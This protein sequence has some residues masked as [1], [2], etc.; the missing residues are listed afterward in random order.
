[1][2][3][4]VDVLLRARMEASEVT[5]SVGQIQKALQGLTLPKGITNDLEKEFNKLGPLLKDYQR[6]LNK[7][8]SNKKDLQNFSALKEQIGDTFGSIKNLVNQANSQTIKL[9]VDTQALDQLQHKITSKTEA[10]EKAYSQVFTKSINSANITDQFNKILQASTKAPTIKG[11]IG[12]AQNLFDTKDYAGYNAELDKIKSKILSLKTTKINLAESLGVKNAEKDL[13]AA[14]QKITSFFNKLKVNENKV[15]AIE[16]LKKELKDLGME[17]EGLDLASKIKGE[18]EISN[19]ASSLDQ[20]QQ[21]FRE[22]GDAAGTAASGILSMQ[23]Q[24]GQLRQSTQYFFSLRNMINL[25][26]RGIDDAVKSIKELDAAMT[27]TAVVTN[28]SVGD[29]WNKLPEYTA[30]ANALGATVQDMYEATTLYYQQGLNTEQAMSIAAETMKMARI[31]GLDAADATDKMTAALRGFNMEINEASA[32]RI[33]DVYSNLAA[34]TASNTEELGTAM[35]RTASIAH[36]AGMSFEGTAAFLAQ[37]IETTREPAENI[38]TAMKTVIARMQEMKKNPLEISEVDGEEVDYNKVDAALKSIGVSLQDVNGNFRDNDKILLEISQRWDS[39]SQTQ[40]R[41]VATT[42]AGSRQQS[43]F[44][45]MVSDYERTMQLM[46]YA[47]DS[48]GASQEQFEKTMDSMEAKLNK[49]HNAWQAFTMGIANNTFVKGAVDGLTFLIDGVNNLIDKLSNGSKTIKSFLSLFTAFTALKGLGRLANAAIGGLGGLLDPQSSFKQGLFGGGAIGN[50][51]S[52]NA[53]QA[54]MISDPIV[55]AINRLYQAQTGKTV[56]SES[57]TNAKADYR[58]FKEANT[59]LR[60][61]ISQLKPGEE[62]SI[63]EAYQHIGKLDNKQQ[64]A[65]L[66]QLPGLS[67]SLQKNGIQFNAKDISRSS[68]DLLNT[69]NKEINQGLQNK[70]L[71]SQAVLK[72]FG[73][74]EDFRKT[75]ATYGDDYIKA[76]EQ[77]LSQTANKYRD[78]LLQEYLNSEYQDLSEEQLNAYLDREVEKKRSQFEQEDLD[79]FATSA[80]AKGANIAN[81]ISKVGTSAT[82]AG[83]GVAQLGMQL[84]QLG[85]TN[86][87]AVV[88]DIGYKISSLGMIA[89]SVGSIIGKVFEAGSGS[90]GAGMLSIINAHPA[91]AAFTAIATAVTVAITAIHRYRTAVKEAAEEVQKNY[92]D[93]IK[94]T[95]DKIESLESNKDIFNRLAKGVDEYGH[96]ISL[97]AEEYEEFLNISKELAET[98]PSLIK[99]YDAEGRAIIAKGEAID[100]VIQKQKELQDSARKDYINA[101]ALDTTIKGIKVADNYNLAINTSEMSKMDLAG[102]SGY[103]LP[104]FNKQ[105]KTLQKSLKKLDS[106]QVAQLNKEITKLTGQKIDLNNL[107]KDGV[108]VLAN[109]YSDINRIIEE[110]GQNLNNKTRENIQQAFTGLGEDYNTFLGDLQPLT[111]Q[112]S[113][114]LDS[115]GMSA[116]GLGLSDEFVGGFNKG[117]E[118]LA[119][120]ATL[121]GWSGARLQR[122]AENYANQFKTLTK[123]GGAY[124]RTLEQIDRLQ[125]DYLQHMGED[126]AID[127]YNSSI[128][129]QVDSLNALAN[130]YENS[131]AAGKAFAEMCRQAAADAQ[132]FTEYGVASLAE[133]LNTLSGEFAYARG[134]EE[135]FKEATK[136]GD[137]YT[138]AEQYKS[139][140]D[141]VMDDKNNAGQGS[142][143]AWRGA[144]E[145]LGA[146]YVDNAKDWNE[147]A[148]QVD[149]ITPMF[150]DGADGVLAFNDYLVEAWETAGNGGDV[151]SK[152]G[153]VVD[154]EFGKDFEFNFANINDNLRE[155]A[156]ELGI[157]EGALAALI[158]KSRQWVP[159]DISDPSMI[160]SALRTSETSMQGT[161]G[162]L[163]T[164]ESSFRDEAYAHEVV[165]DNYKTTKE[166]L[167]KEQNVEFLTVDKL[168]SKD[169]SG[170]AYANNILRDLGISSENQNN[171][172]KNA[173]QAYSKLG[174]GLE[175]IQKV[176]T[177]DGIALQEGKVTAEDVEEAYNEQ[178]F[179]QENPT[180]AGIANDT[181]VIASNTSAMLT[182]MGILSKDAEKDIEQATNGQHLRDIEDTFKTDVRN[183]TTGKEHETARN[184]V[185]SEIDNYDSSISLLQKGQSG[186]TEGSKEWNK[187]QGY[188]DKL[189]EAR[190]RLQDALD[191]DAD[192]FEEKKQAIAETL[193]N[194]GANTADQEFINANALEFDAALNN[195]DLN[196]GIASL[197][198][199][200]EEGDLSHQSLFNLAQQFQALHSEDLSD[201]TYGQ[202]SNLY[203]QLGL[204]A[205]ESRELY[206]SLN[207]LSNEQIQILLDYDV[208]GEDKVNNFLATLNQEFGDGSVKTQKVLIDAQLE[209][210]KGNSKG[211]KELLQEQ[212][213]LDEDK[214][215]TVTKKMEVAVETDV[216][217]E[218]N[219]QSIKDSIADL[220]DDQDVSVTVNYTKGGQEEPEAKDAD[221]HYKKTGQD[222]P[223]SKNANLKYKKTGQD[224]P[225]D[226]N[227]NL[228]Y[229]KTGQDEPVDKTAD[230][231]YALGSQAPPKDK[232]AYVTYKERYKGQNNHI[233]ARSSISIN[234]A[235]SGMNNGSFAGRNIGGKATQKKQIALTGEK[236]FEIAWIPSEQRAVILGE[237]GPEVANFPSDTVIY[238]NEQ[239]KKILKGNPNRKSFDSFA[240]GRSGGIR[241]STLKYTGSSGGS[242]GS[243]G[244][245]G[246]SDKKTD[247]KTKKSS[248][249][250]GKVSVWWLNQVRKVDAVTRKMDKAADNFNKLIKRMGTTRETANKSLAAYKKTINQTIKL[251]KASLA[252]AN[253]EL[254]NLDTNKN[255][256]QTIKWGKDKKES[257]S[258]AGYIKKDKATGAYTIDQAAINKVA[259]TDKEKATAIRDAAEKEINDRVSKQKS[260]EDAIKK[261]QDALNELSNQMYETFGRWE[262]SINRIYLLS[263]RL[264]VLTKQVENAGSRVDLELDKIKAIGSDDNSYD[265]IINALKAETDSMTE[266][267]RAESANLDAVIQDFKDSLN[268]KTYYQI[269]QKDP[270]STA[271]KDDFFAAKRALM[272][273]EEDSVKNPDGSYNYRAVLDA[274]NNTG[275]SKEKYEAIKGVI[276]KIFEKQN[277]VYDTINEAYGSVAELYQRMEE[278]QSFISDFESELLNGL[279]EQT[280]QE[281]NKLEK[282]NDSL[283]DALKDLLDEVKEKLE[284]RRKA[285]DNKKTESD[286]SKKQ[287]RLNLLR[288]DTSGSHATEIAQL[289]KE[290]ADARQDYQRSLEDQLLDKLQ[291]QGDEAAKQRERQIK[292]LDAQRT[293]AQATGV[294]IA[295]VKEWMKNPETYKADM[296]EAWLAGK[297]YEDAGPAEREQL[298]QEFEAT[299]AQFRGYQNELANLDTI[300]SILEEI[301]QSIDNKN[302]SDNT[303]ADPIVAAK[304]I[305][306]KGWTATKARKAGYLASTLYGAGYSAK[307]IHDAGYSAKEFKEG[308][309]LSAADAIKAGYSGKEVAAAYGASAA[310]IGANVSGKA[311]QAGS[312]A[313]AKKLQEIVN[314][315][316]DDKATQADMAGV[317]VGKVTIDTNGSKKGGNKTIN[318][319]HIS[320]DGHTVGANIGSTLYTA[321]WDEKTGTIKGKWKKIP[322]GKLTPAL[323]K[324]YPIDGKQALERAI[325]N[326]AVGKKIS[327][328]FKSLVAAANIIGKKYKLSN[329]IYGSI[330]QDG[331]IFYNKGK[332]GVY[333]WNPS[334]STKPAFEKYNKS[335]FMK[336]AHYKNVGSEYAQVLK[337]NGITK[338]KTGGL[339]DYTGPAWLDGTKSKPEL[340]LN[341]QDTKNFLALKDVLS[342]VM[343]STTNLNNTYGGDMNFDININVDH[344][345]SDYD[346][347]KIADRIKKKIVQDS[348]YRNVTQ[349]RKFR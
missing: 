178:Q 284:E 321:D 330:S 246:G 237:R 285:E 328:N 245:G 272:L 51:A 30:N 147:V 213:G 27:E 340:V 144:T 90:F 265:K 188:I 271:A 189:T 234:S 182:A 231:N 164:S 168:V 332:E 57:Q 114:Y 125:K 93:T 235:A 138:A 280:K 73:T 54:R 10:L 122:E 339:A 301:A 206:M 158:D 241:S 233:S 305:K 238:T 277:A 88:T 117:L 263:Q 306:A 175:D 11:M 19:I 264:E 176:L 247:K 227:A 322:I 211:A 12:S 212:L 327:G 133:G 50:K 28:F 52:A 75:M 311:A 343:S 228:K 21:G 128:Q 171:T 197:K 250:G 85:M 160:M 239:S 347:D 142:L 13:S 89:S 308:T 177:S 258:L 55:N 97:T 324:K 9:K 14:E 230:V 41:Y 86:V 187:Y 101:G 72:M 248:S 244:G 2:A 136:G 205:T 67:L 344:I 45:A 119:M 5:S 338:Y 333:K 192:S 105:V 149:R 148:K 83:Q 80:Q 39:L 174:F 217:G 291:K 346:V 281:I 48:A 207:G 299:F 43:R 223:A 143:T 123:D 243:G 65:I 110:N 336:K 266:K 121:E 161:G 191:K 222:E 113:A 16:L 170:Q 341:A 251:N 56:T 310:M 262:K 195:T 314:K 58:A 78:A 172:L 152:L 181:G 259:K 151:L 77:V 288:A 201:L 320:A 232:T 81:A 342:H 109:N 70:T 159:W 87:G 35:Q 94:E 254:K 74:P 199:L 135:R 312:G 23:D 296:R 137:Y 304:D 157:S 198:A 62:F 111:E 7:G 91:I 1:M 183:A 261:A 218:D 202:L 22:T 219:L 317:S 53:A 127:D 131:G 292:L 71:D 61:A 153:K 318:D 60:Q 290:L 79:R 273:L 229:K 309:G 165:G 179:A 323:I 270:N 337:A 289:E 69:F 33:N 102:K 279:E 216:V 154:G 8:F 214:A 130:Q 47:N 319:A 145:L 180:V 215:E 331:W 194:L 17:V 100:E 242:G 44:I 59:G 208:S 31:A 185:Q 36:S 68:K 15:Q 42:I 173:V 150:E 325:E 64:Q 326:T 118:D 37:A 26:K 169:K 253:K 255:R 257:I 300:T 287:Q 120:D 63:S 345:N 316:K 84:T 106:K 334:K 38:G 252:Q 6:Q 34:K 134:A 146:N 167:E 162:K 315:S 209:V 108:R 294:D 276:D 40:Q 203:T 268:L 4:T 200:R 220:P 274:L 141:T 307:Q 297:G 24:V 115:K 295:T 196:A 184:K 46:G 335:N 124:S 82:M 126:G 283:T 298:E 155:F 193:N 132:N 139:I 226:K 221:M 99:G 260:A 204:T 163:Y 240:S 156:D 286:I 103:N 25:F 267:A 20:V 256:K 293:I 29:M 98:S 269:Y 76:G 18:E 236:G 275:Y 313:S 210:A 302:T 129:T 96:N 140:I 348:S 225:E 66:Q 107:T 32:Q 190:D 329:G 3:E 95:T 166:H 104:F 112:I 303:T 282:L 249:N 116:L 92:N 186:L 278:M 349:V 49:L 224:E